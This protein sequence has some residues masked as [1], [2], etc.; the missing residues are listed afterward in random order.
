MGLTVEVA[1]KSD[2]GCVRKN[3]EDN[4]GWDTRAGIFVVCDGMGGAAAGEV[5]SKMGV[6]KLLA[7]FRDGMGSGVYPQAG[8]SLQGVSERAQRLS[9]AI[10]LAN[11]SIH[12]VGSQKASH[13]GMGSTIVA[14]AV[15]TGGESFSIGHVGDSRIYLIREG[16]IRQLTNDHSLVMEQVRRGLITKEEAEHSEMQNI[17]IRALGSE[18]TVQPDLEDLAALPGDILLLASDGLT[19]HVKD[20]A[21][22]AMVQE[23]PSLEAA[24]DK[25]I[26]AAKEHGGDDNITCV[27]VRMA[28]Q[29]WYRKLIPGSGG[30]G[31]QNS[32]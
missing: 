13:R 6:D 22:L 4:L 1:G 11:A 25:L 27:L 24:C 19:K 8:P 16:A 15:A 32:L 23:A 10:H 18:A 3:N 28:E 17:I 31:W 30:T 9:S 5:A 29:P 26:Q 14:V 7:Y 12:Q 2:V 21:I 20:E